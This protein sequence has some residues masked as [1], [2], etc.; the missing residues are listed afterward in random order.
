MK[1]K[2]LLLL[3]LE[4]PSRQVA[5]RLKVPPRTSAVCQASNKNKEVYKLLIM[6]LV[7]KS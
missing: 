6:M 7:Y 1:E 5:L 3:L 4:V 2:L